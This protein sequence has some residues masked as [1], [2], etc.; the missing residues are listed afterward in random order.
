MSDQNLV[1]TP[2]GG[3]VSKET[4]STGQVPQGGT[5][6]T[7]VSE[8]DK[9]V[10]EA[11]AKFQQDINNLKSSFQKSEFQLRK[12]ME[13]QRKAYDA[14]VR[15]LTL[16]SMDA[17]SRKKFEAEELVEKNRNYEAEALAAK[18]AL[19]EME[20]KNQY[21]DFFVS[22]G[23]PLSEL[24]TDKDLTTLVNSGWAAWKKKTD[25][26]EKQLAKLQK[27]GSDDDE[28]KPPEVS[29]AKG[30]PPA[31]A[32]WADLIKKYG[33]EENVW[34]LIDLGKLD[35]AILP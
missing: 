24:A 16:K 18:Q 26:L 25:D 10:L 12:E 1:T 8:A 20:Q 5:L 14:H 9:K 19:A 33:T 4:L 29:T 31:K 27:Q 6:P 11:T 7:D 22:N 3:E 15:E 35:P 34:K 32:T 21:R 28:V 13:E 2:E 30:K 17:E 23:V